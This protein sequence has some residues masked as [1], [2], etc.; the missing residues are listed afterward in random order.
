MGAGMQRAW[1]V[2]VV[3]WSIVSTSLFV[4]SFWNPEIDA[5]LTRLD[6]NV[7]SILIGLAFIWKVWTSVIWPTFGHLSQRV[8]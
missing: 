7:C 6:G 2:A 3:T 5:P 1:W 8:R 4:V